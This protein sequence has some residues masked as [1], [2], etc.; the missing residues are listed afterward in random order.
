MALNE[1]QIA[2]LVR[3]VLIEIGDLPVAPDIDGE[4]VPC[5]RLPSD[6][7]QGQIP[8]RRSPG[9]YLLGRYRPGPLTV[10]QTQIASPP[11]CRAR[12]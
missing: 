10:R 1:E 7:H 11:G 2:R 6:E 8:R 3:E 5:I 4:S 12:C 9:R